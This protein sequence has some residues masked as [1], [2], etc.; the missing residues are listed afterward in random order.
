MAQ[1]ERQPNPSGASAGMPEVEVYSPVA[2]A[3][4]W[5]VLV[6]LVIQIPVGLV[7]AYRGN[8]L[9]VWDALTNNLYSS[10]KLLGVTILAIVLARLAYRLLHGAPADEPTLEWWQKAASHVTHWSLY[11][12]L[13]VVPLLG[14]LG[15]SRYPALNIFG[16]F[17]LPGLV[18]PDK[19]AAEAFFFLHKALAIV[20]VLLIGAHVGAAMFHHFIRKDGVLTRMLP[21]LR[22]R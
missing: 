12:M 11:G 8:V 13:I 9:N 22:R 7:M 10:H 15:V 2:R 21:G 14:W 3:F 19:Q 4:H 18:A 5:I 20:L 6:L 1:R 16:L 17:N